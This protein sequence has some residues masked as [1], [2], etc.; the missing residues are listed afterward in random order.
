MPVR[1]RKLALVT[2]TSS[3]IGL[4]L[5][6]MLLDAGWDVA[7]VSRRSAPIA[8]PRYQHACMDL[9]DL[10]ALAGELENRFASTVQDDSF[11]RVALVNNAASP[12]LLAPVETFDPIALSAVYAVNVI[13]PVWCMGFVS[14]HCRHEAALRIV[15]VSSAAGVHAFPG[16]AAYGSAKAALRMAGAVLA[17]EWQSTVPHAPTRANASI[18]SY[19]PGTVDT[20]MQEA[21]RSRS[22]EEFP[23]V[24]MFAAMRAQG[25][26]VSPDRPAKD[27]AEFLESDGQPAFAE[28]RLG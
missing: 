20:P 25:M 19:E 13:A 26:L 3:G 16:M 28:R 21:A 1:V 11:A 8:H 18:L 2:G 23:W 27:I 7:G 24:G 14:R 9:A 5:S 12:D 15:N 6:R 10:S 22:P 17:A 4:A